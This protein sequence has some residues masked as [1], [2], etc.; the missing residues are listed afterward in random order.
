MVFEG[1]CHLVDQLGL[2]VQILI[3]HA[4]T[5][6]F[7]DTRIAIIY[8]LCP[9]VEP[10]VRVLTISILLTTTRWP[11]YCASILRTLKLFEN[12]E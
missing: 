3:L 9:Q 5:N 1:I 8:H 6:F 10:N 12:V 2:L 11:S 4:I 7:R